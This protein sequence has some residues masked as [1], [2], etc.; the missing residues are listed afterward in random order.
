MHIY[1]LLLA[2]NQQLAEAHARQLAERRRL[3]ARA[4][5]KGGKTQP[6][7]PL[8]PEPKQT[9]LTNVLLITA[10]ADLDDLIYVFEVLFPRLR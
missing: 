8:P 4:K 7:A 10:W 9:Q 2:C 1:R 3:Q 5:K 6:L